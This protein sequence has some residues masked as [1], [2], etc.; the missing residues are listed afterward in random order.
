MTTQRR[1][2]YP[3]FKR[4]AAH[5]MLKQHCSFIE[6]LGVV[7][8]S[9]ISNILSRALVVEGPNQVWCGDITYI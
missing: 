6:S 7:E 4:K 5:L 1:T 3:K 2:F 8:R 9:D